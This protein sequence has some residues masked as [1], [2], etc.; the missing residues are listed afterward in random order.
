MFRLSAFQDRLLQWLESNPDAVIPPSRHA[1]VTSFIRSGLKDLSVSRKTSAV[2]WGIHVPND[3]SHMVY[4]WL[5]ALTNYL[6][7]LGH[8]HSDVASP[9]SPWPAKF[10][11]VGKDI[12]RFHAVYWPAFLMALELPLPQHIVAH[13]WWTRGGRKMSKSIGNVV[14]PNTLL[15]HLSSDQFRFYLCREGGALGGDIDFD[16]ERVAIRVTN[17]LAN[18]LGNLVRRVLTPALYRDPGITPTPGELTSED[19][20]IRDVLNCLEGDMG[21]HMDRFLV[22]LSLESTWQVVRATNKY[23]AVAAPWALRKGEEP[24]QGRA[25]TVMYVA[26]EALRIVG[27]ALQPF[28]PDA[29]ATL[30]SQ[31][32]V[33]EDRRAGRDMKFGVI[34]AGHPLDLSPLILFPKIDANVLLGNDADDAMPVSERACIPYSHHNKEKKKEKEKSKKNMKGGGYIRSKGSELPA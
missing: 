9:Q 29:S 17:E 11:V 26:L 12:L 15:E 4:V 3:S 18:E 25:D 22:H 28:T 19:E 31:L 21:Q 5:D 24:E 2:A 10:Q 1:E 30:L 33:P 34:N 7:A 27:I 32:G 6:T 23:L 16:E 13:G 8:P 14:D 20:A